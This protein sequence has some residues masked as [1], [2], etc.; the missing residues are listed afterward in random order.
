MGH[1]DPYEAPIQRNESSKILQINGCKQRN[2]CQKL[3]MVARTILRDRPRKNQVHIEKTDIKTDPYVF[4]LKNPGDKI[5]RQRY[6]A[7]R[8]PQLYNTK[9]TRILKITSNKGQDSKIELIQD[10]A[11]SI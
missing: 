10:V 8:I 2:W 3:T 4:F 1:E 6:I 9:K 11:H 5:T 7:Y